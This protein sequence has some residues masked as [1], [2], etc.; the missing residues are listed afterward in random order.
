MIESG[1]RRSSVAQCTL[2]VDT[3]TS[4]PWSLLL[5]SS[6]AGVLLVKV[7]AVRR[8]GVLLLLVEE[9]QKRGSGER[10]NIRQPKL[11]LPLIVLSDV[12]ERGQELADMRPRG[13]WC[14][15]RKIGIGLVKVVGAAR[16]RQW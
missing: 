9:S 14:E 1:R 15:L 2:R 8:Y 12:W 13:S 6:L 4:L 3:A 7:R 10:S 16:N 11:T 5:P